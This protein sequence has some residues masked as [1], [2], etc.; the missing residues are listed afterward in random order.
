MGYRYGQ[1]ACIPMSTVDPQ[2][3]T[4]AGSGSLVTHGA[5]GPGRG[6]CMLCMAGVRMHALTCMASAANSTSRPEGDRLY[7]R[8]F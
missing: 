1:H 5:P 8:E 6:S 3:G 7:R 4:H 2:L